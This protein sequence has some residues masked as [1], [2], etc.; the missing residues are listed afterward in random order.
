MWFNLDINCVRR[1]VKSGGNQQKGSGR[2]YTFPRINEK[3]ESEIEDLLQKGTRITLMKV[4][5]LGE[6]YIQDGDRGFRCSKGW[7]AKLVKR[8]NNEDLIREAMDN[9]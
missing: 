3:V 6:K 9:I 7:A 8:F 5:H 2:K 4:M 1:W